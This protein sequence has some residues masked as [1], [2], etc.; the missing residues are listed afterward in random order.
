M[1]LN[2]A[3]L[4]ALSGLQVN[5][6]LLD[7][8]SQNVANVNT[9]GYSRK[10]ASAES[11]VLSGTGAGVRLGAVTRNVNE[12]LLA[13]LR[14]QASFLGQSE[15]LNAFYGRMQDLFGTPSSQGS[16]GTEIGAMADAFQALAAQPEDASRRITVVN[17]ARFLAD[18]FNSIA[19]QIQ[20]LRQETDNDITDAITLINDKLIE[21]QDL[22]LR[23]AQGLATN[24]GVT[25]LQDAR[26]RAVNEIAD[27]LDIRYFVRDNG[28]MVIFTAQGRTL[29]DRVANQLSHTA[30]GTM[31]ASITWAGGSIDGITLGTADITSEIGTG[32]LA[33]LIELRDTTLPN[34]ASQ[35]DE[36]AAALAEEINAVHN[37]G[38]AFPGNATLTGQRRFA[39]GD[40]P[41]WTGTARVAVTAADGTVVEVLDV[42]LGATA[43]M[44]ALVTAIDGM[45]NATCALNANGQMVIT[46]TGGNTIA[47]SEMNS[48]VTVGA[49]SVG[50]GEFAGL[51]DFFTAGVDYATY[52]S[53]QQTSDSTALGLAGTLTFQGVFGTTNVVY[54]VGNDLSDLATSINANATLTAAG[55]SATV[56]TDGD[57]Y[58]LRI[59]DV[60]GQNFFITDTGAL[61]STL[62]FKARGAQT[63]ADLGVRTDLLSDPGRVAHAA[64]SN[65]PAL[66]AGMIGVGAGDNSIAQA[67]ANKFTEKLSF[68]PTGQLATASRSLSEYG[69]AILGLNATQASSA[70]GTLEWR[71]ALF[72]ALSNKAASISAVN[73]DEETANMVLLQNA[74]AASARV[75]STTA[76]LFDVLIGIKR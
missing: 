46:A 37:Q 42:N 20:E 74:Y 23:I 69:A 70:E 14:Q 58:R 27:K 26:D 13:D 1:S 75:I 53:A 28:E 8:T 76:E 18:Q 12:T 30:A 73:L 39:A 3:L 68:P 24:E 65:D 59:Q 67:L 15:V 6:R 32:E 54:V 10:I 36:L 25:D 62:A 55:I 29:L 7:L 40:T 52:T 34:L 66:A 45:A 56:V 48:A 47:I 38:T 41:A 16:I 64:L 50:W 22:N 9:E 51:N 4:N 72:E 17:R 31:S 44:G 60:G 33:A 21:I 57:G 35:F 61:V 19:L 43:T 5:Q 71:N 49:R 11:V 63:A 2:V